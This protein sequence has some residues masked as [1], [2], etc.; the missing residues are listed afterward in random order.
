MMNSFNIDGN[1]IVGNLPTAWATWTNIRQ[2]LGNDNQMTGTVPIS[3]ITN[4][5]NI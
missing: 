4:R 3:W 2:F 5:Q 1:N